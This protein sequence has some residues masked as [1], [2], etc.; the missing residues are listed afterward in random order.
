M[1]LKQTAPNPSQVCIYTLMHKLTNHHTQMD[2]HKLQSLMYSIELYCL[3][4]HTFW[5]RKET[6]EMKTSKWFDFTVFCETRW[7]GTNC[8]NDPIFITYIQSSVSEMKVIDLV[9]TEQEV[10]L[11]RTPLLARKL[12]IS[13]VQEVKT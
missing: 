1:E 12:K 13:Y 7:N 4:M 3:M 5:E 8:E 11:Q 6:D 2:T 10:H 9:L